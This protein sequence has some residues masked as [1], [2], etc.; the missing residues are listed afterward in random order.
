[1]RNCAF[2]ARHGLY[3]EEANLG[4]RFF[5][6]V[7]LDVEAGNALEDDTIDNTVDYGVAFKVVEEIVTKTRRHLI[8]ALANDIVKALLA[9]F[10]TITRARITVR[11]PSAPIQGVLDY[12]QVSVEQV[13]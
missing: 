7:E 10:E 8:E 6:D 12:V 1:M 9:R 4:Q 2:F 11:K 3:E 13:R 5:V